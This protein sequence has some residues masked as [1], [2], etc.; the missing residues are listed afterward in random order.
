MR[1]KKIVPK[2][3]YNARQG[4]GRFFLIDHPDQEKNKKSFATLAPLRF[5][6]SPKSVEPVESVSK[7]NIYS[8][9]PDMQHRNNVPLAHTITGI[10]FVVDNNI[11]FRHTANAVLKQAGLPKKF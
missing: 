10:R 11:K 2:D 6:R 8:I 7:N 5:H 9:S 1:I 4:I 3:I